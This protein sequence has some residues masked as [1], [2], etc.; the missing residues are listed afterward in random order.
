MKTC[1]DCGHELPVTEFYPGRAI[2][3]PCRKA[4]GRRYWHKKGKHNAKRRQAAKAK[5][6][7]CA[8]CKKVRPKKEFGEKATTSDGLTAW[9][10]DCRSEYNKQYYR[11]MRASIPTREKFHPQFVPKG[12]QYNFEQRRILVA[13]KAAY[14]EDDGYHERFVNY[15]CARPLIRDG[16]IRYGEGM[17]YLAVRP[18]VV[19]YILDT[20]VG[21]LSDDVKQIFR[22]GVNNE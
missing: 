4:A 7:K 19:D 20:P 10:K 22:I 11:G 6:K 1:N 2:C 14:F 3:I 8:R 9:C 16:L 12:K 13:V 18:A 15:E 21:Y 5:K 17:Y